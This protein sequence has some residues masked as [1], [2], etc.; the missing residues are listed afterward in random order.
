MTVSIIRTGRP[1]AQIKLFYQHENLM[2]GLE[3]ALGSGVVR[4]TWVLRAGVILAKA[5]IYSAN[6]KYA[7][8]MC[9]IP[10][11]RQTQVRL[12]ARMTAT[13]NAHISR[14]SPVF[15]LRWRLKRRKVQNPVTWGRRFEY[16]LTLP[17][18]K[19]WAGG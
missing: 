8:S 11:P 17:L 6:L 1:L 7:L 2:V 13:C 3:V 18:S 16:N 10:V 5:G 15:S 14:M 9:S 19:M 4:E 12:L